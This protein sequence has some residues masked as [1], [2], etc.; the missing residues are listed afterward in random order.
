MDLAFDDRRIDGAADIVDRR[1]A[2]DRELPRLGV[3]LDLAG[4]RAVGVRVQPRRNLFGRRQ[5]R[6]GG[7][8]EQPDRPVSAEDRK[9]AVRVADIGGRGFQQ[10]GRLLAPLFNDPPRGAIEDRTAQPHRPVGMGP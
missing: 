8:F 2:D 3:D 5:R 7:D 10:T 1:V 6:L 9:A 4:G